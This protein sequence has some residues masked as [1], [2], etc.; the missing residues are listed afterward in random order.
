M[1]LIPA[2]AQMFILVPHRQDAGQ[3]GIPAFKKLYEEKKGAFLHY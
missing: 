1:G 3:S 2:S